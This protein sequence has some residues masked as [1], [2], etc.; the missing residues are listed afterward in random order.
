LIAILVFVVIYYLIKFLTK[1]AEEKIESNVL[2]PDIYSK[3]ISAL[4]GN[5]IYIVLMIFNV[6]AVFQIIGFDMAILM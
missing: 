5:I 6:L 2:Q 1:K 3:K 4:A